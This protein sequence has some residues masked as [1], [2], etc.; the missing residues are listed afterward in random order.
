MTLLIVWTAFVSALLA[1]AAAAG[2]RAAAAL[3]A[4]RRVVWLLA[5][6]FAMAVPVAVANDGVNNRNMNEGAM[7]ADGA[8]AAISPRRLRHVP[9]A[10]LQ[11]SYTGCRWA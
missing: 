1:G 6:F 2:E 7:P 3:G 5:I 11:G 9:L 8:N 4:P 10:T